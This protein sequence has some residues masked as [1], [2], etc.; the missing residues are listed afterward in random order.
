M[1]ANGTLNVVLSFSRTRKRVYSIKWMYTGNI[2]QSSDVDHAIKSE[3]TLERPHYFS[4]GSTVH[5]IEIH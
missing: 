1:I 3:C 4:R 2:V 5:T